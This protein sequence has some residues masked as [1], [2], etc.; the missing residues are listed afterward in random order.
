MKKPKRIK[1]GKSAADG[2]NAGGEP[3]DFEWLAALEH[4]LSEWL[5]END[6]RACRDL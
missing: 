2:A 4:T 6:D 3:I 5:S 1:K